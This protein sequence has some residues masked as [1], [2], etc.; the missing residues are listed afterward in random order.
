M[1]TACALLACWGMNRL[2]A[3]WFYAS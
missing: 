2:L 1:Y 3:R